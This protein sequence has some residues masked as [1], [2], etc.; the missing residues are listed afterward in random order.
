MSRSIVCIIA[1]VAGALV[2]PAVVATDTSPGIPGRIKYEAEEPG[3]RVGSSIDLAGDLD[4]DG[5]DD[6]IVGAPS[7]SA[8]APGAGRA[9][10]LF[11]SSSRQGSVPV[12][13]GGPFTEITGSG[14]DEALGASVAGIGDFDG[15]G[16]LDLAVAAPSAARGAGE[17]AEAGV[18]WILYG[19]DAWPATV[20]VT[21]PDTTRIIGAGAG[22]HAGL[23]ISGAGDVD[24]DGRTDLIIGAPDA[25]QDGTSRAGRAYLL[26]GSAA[27]PAALDLASDADVV[28]SGATSLG[29]LGWCVAG[30]GDLNDD[31]LSDVAIGSPYRGDGLAG[32][33]IVVYGSSDLPEAIDA[34]ASLA[35]LGF[36]L[37]G[38]APG[39]RLGWSVSG[40]DVSGDRQADLIVGAPYED[41]PTAAPG[42][43]QRGA[44]YAV[45][46]QE[47]IPDEITTAQVPDLG[48]VIEGEADHGLLGY[49]VAGVGDVNASGNPDFAISAPRLDNGA[50]AEAGV[51]YI[52]FGRPTWPSS[53]LVSLTDWEYYGRRHASEQAQVHFGETLARA[54][55]HVG[56]GGADVAAGAPTWSPGSTAGSGV[57]SVFYGWA[58]PSPTGLACTPTLRDVALTWETEY[59]YDRIEVLRDG[60]LVATLAGD[61]TDWVDSDVPPGAHSY[62]LVAVAPGI[63]GGDEPVDGTR[64]EPVT[65]EVWVQVLPPVS[66][67]C[68]A[69]DGDVLLTWS[70]GMT[71]DA[72]EVLRDGEPI[73]HIDGADTAWTDEDVP[74]GLHAYEVRG[75]VEDLASIPAGCDVS[76]PL[77]PTDLTCDV[78][79][80]TV[81]LRWTEPEGYDRVEVFRDGASLAV[82]PGGVLET[83]DTDVEPGGHEYAVRGLLGD[84]SGARVACSVVVVPV[85]TDVSCQVEGTTGR[86]AWSNAATYESI[87]VTVDGE[88]VAT[89]PGD[90]TEVTIEALETGL[91]RLAVAAEVAG[92]FVSETTECEV[93]V[94][95]PPTDL[96]C[97]AE[98][99]VVSLVWTR[100][101]AYDEIAVLLDGEEV[102]RIDGSANQHVAEGVP[103]GLHAWS[104]L[105]IG[106]RTV[107]LAATCESLVLVPPGDLTC[108]ADGG[109]VALAWLAVDGAESVELLRDDTLLATIPGDS[110]GYLDTDVPVGT[111]RYEVVGV[112]TG[113]RS[114]PA[115]CE[116]IHPGAPSA[117][118]CAA[119]GD[120]VTLTWE[121]GGAYETVAVYRGEALL[122]TLA[123]GAM[124]YTDLGVAADTPHVYHVRGGVGPHFSK[125]ASCEIRI[126]LAPTGV[127]CSASAGTVRVEWTPPAMR[128]GFVVLRDGAE[129]ATLPADASVFEESV[130]VPGEYTYEVRTRLGSAV[131][132]AATCDVATIEPPTDVTCRSVAGTAELSW[133]AEG[134]DSIIVLRDG[135]EVAVLE[136]TAG[137]YSDPDL[138]PGDYL[139]ELVAVRG[140][141]ES[142]PRACELHAPAAPPEL[143]CMAGD[144]G[145]TL[146][147]SAPESYDQVTVLRDSTEIAELP[148]DS[149]GHLDPEVEPDVEYAYEV[150]GRTGEST[151]VPVACSIR[152]PVTP[153]DLSCQANG[154]SVEISWTTGE[155]YDEII[156]SRNGE[157]INT[158]DGSATTYG[159]PDLAAGVYTYSVRGRTDAVVSRAVTCEV[160]VVP[161]VEDLICAP[162]EASIRIRV[163]WTNPVLFETITV[164]RDGEPIAEGL[165]GETTEYVEEVSG[166]GSWVYEVVGHAFG[167]SSLAATCTAERLEPL[168][169]RGD[170]NHDADVDI[171]DAV[172]TL[173]YL[174]QGG[175]PPP[176]M[177]SAD[178][179]DDGSV[180]I[181][182]PITTLIWLFFD[183]PPPPPPFP[184]LGVDPTPDG[185]DVDDDLGCDE[186][187]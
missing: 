153:S 19:R 101:E 121:N 75:S 45:F 115:E 164:L 155:E 49:A 5:T 2:T 48:V 18:V 176:C 7:S 15:D 56:N 11:G 62:S 28:I 128:D 156:V 129:V 110:T 87:H 162:E 171:A 42:A 74:P 105:G 94:L 78:D 165:D 51:V 14:P 40:G 32:E 142:G 141:S 68:A 82:L 35:G 184:E 47:A 89:L 117:L 73:A 8:S 17:G 149:T 52:L 113:S 181:A 124:A 144:D 145:I 93:R 86:L 131:G 67:A 69:R 108:V 100:G 38:E 23:S 127:G 182:D 44:V 140:S 122:A 27:R 3:G 88:I 83:T 170:S 76:V 133:T 187:W 134:A 33:V 179:N 186:P 16:R 98:G 10:I 157:P 159:D 64:T 109:E 12:P 80:Q 167:S 91:R 29:R 84:N 22:E 150:I 96:Q 146:A 112:A 118:S 92:G 53:R 79:G 183:G 102:A 138:S 41:S 173:N 57:V 135:A 166:T 120:Q 130:A 39:G 175:T 107:S 1:L 85:P 95:A 111:H 9:Y 126:P 161:P 169:I 158:L 13:T 104:I 148:G 36:R 143:H 177:D 6:L 26:L 72:I 31:G 58:I 71:Y 139:Y 119:L 116:V 4:G 168:F 123:G 46:G 30:V 54:G 172:W 59:P 50:A 174:F 99:D 25:D 106:D 97:S 137:G 125:P 34:D 151:T 37:R 55:D 147:W 90:A 60:A 70:N 132:A 43:V 136:G 61:A 20:D 77:R 180:E 63:P 152:I 21:G 160:T 114:A 163:T 185:P 154:S 65:C 66:V 81:T 178:A 103:A 24:G